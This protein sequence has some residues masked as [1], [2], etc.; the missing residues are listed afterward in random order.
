MAMIYTLVTSAKE[1]LADQ[2]GQDAGNEDAVAEEAAKDEV[3]MPFL[4]M[5]IPF[6]VSVLI[7][8][9]FIEHLL[10][11]EASKIT[12]NEPKILAITF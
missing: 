7:Y 9:S 8:I 3:R 5:I 11:N 4:V 6:C 2:F 10:M 1:W 12:D